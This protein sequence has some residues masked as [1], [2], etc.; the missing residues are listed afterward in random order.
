ML[1]LILKKIGFILLKFLIKIFKVLFDLLNNVDKDI[2]IM[3]ISILINHLINNGMIRVLIYY[4]YFMNN[5][6]ING[7]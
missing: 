6:D 4:F 2:L 1:N 7:H 3:L 5:M